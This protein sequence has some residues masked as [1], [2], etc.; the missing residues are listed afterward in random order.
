MNDESRL[1]KNRIETLTDNIFAVA[2]T[3]LVLNISVPNISSHSV[4]SF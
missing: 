2:M 3:L 1:G 4:G